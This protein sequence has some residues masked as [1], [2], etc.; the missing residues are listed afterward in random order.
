[1]R[2]AAAISCSRCIYLARRNAAGHVLNYLKRMGDQCR[3][4]VTPYL[5]YAQEVGS[6]VRSR[7]LV[8]SMARARC[9]TRAL[10]VDGA[11]AIVRPIH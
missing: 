5:L 1:M 6:K 11:S 8:F 2:F 7:G 4:E 3:G 9:E 10:I